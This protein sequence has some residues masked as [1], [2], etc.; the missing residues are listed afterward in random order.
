MN[1]ST[2]RE[3][4]SCLDEDR[5]GV[6]QESATW[7][8]SEHATGV[9]SARCGGQVHLSHNA[10]SPLRRRHDERPQRQ[11][12]TQYIKYEGIFR[13]K[14]IVGTLKPRSHRISPK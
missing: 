13:T 1:G 6:E 4:S 5:G 14:N 11:N 8:A 7:L 2:V 3:D 12:A 9:R 10:S